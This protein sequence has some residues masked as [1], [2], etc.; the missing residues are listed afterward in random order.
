MN[1]G[2][3]ATEPPDAMTTCTLL[4]GAAPSVINAYELDPLSDSRWEPFV[5]SHPQASV[6][7]SSH[8]LRALQIA[9]GYEPVVLTTSPSN[10]T[11]MD[12]LVF[13]RVRSWLT[14]S[15]LVSLPFSDH[16]ELLASDGATLSELL[17]RTR[18]REAGKC[19]FIEIR[20][21]SYR[22]KIRDGFRQ[23]D[24][25]LIHHL[26]LCKSKADLFK[27]L[28]KSSLQGKIRK[29][30][31]E[32]IYYEEGTSPDLL[33]KFYRLMVATRRRH[34]L[35]PQPLSWFRTLV[36]TFGAHLKI[37]VASNNGLPI[38]SII[39]FSHKR[40]MIYKYGC[41][42]AR[43]HR[44][45][46][47]ALL[48]WHAIQDAKENGSEELDMG[49]SDLDNPG[50]ISF[51]ERFGAVGKPLHYWRYPDKPRPMLDAGKKAFI[52]QVVRATPN[53]VLKATG[54][55]LYPHIG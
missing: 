53:S 36:E 7:H 9:Y 14:G 48:L 16:S 18:E 28:H 23:S 27:S 12:G 21:I 8:W 52:R 26:D 37:R 40:S 11:L 46:G 1:C 33:G 45:G 30:E 51:K 32:G 34:G 5:N 41:S 13:C 3:G 55:F 4:H 54:K 38:A 35:P 50:L 20:P 47:I 17:M 15:R 43:F 2:L 44:F 49:R 24:S 22:P 31:R 29:A 39:T 25:Y 10:A 19:R 6:F 42:D